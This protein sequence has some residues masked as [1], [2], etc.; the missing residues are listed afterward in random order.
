MEFRIV[1]KEAFDV[2]VKTQSV[3]M[4][5]GANPIPA[6]WDEYFS[7]GLHT[8]VAPALGVC[9]QMDT[10]SGEFMYGIGDFILESRDIP[11]G[12]QVW[13]A[14]KCTWAVFTCVGSIPFAIKEMWDKIH[15]QW[16]P[17]AEYEHVQG[18]IDLELYTDGDVTSPD[19]V[20]EIWLPVR[21]KVSS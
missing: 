13:S 6:M 17:N 14:P 7:E 10:E 4:K 20:S 8:K 12:F 18:V 15:S 2:V 3:I 11:D 1:E 19:Y 5:D 9:G 16:M 21:Q